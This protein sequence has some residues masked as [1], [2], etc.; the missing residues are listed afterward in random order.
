M[1]FASC[2]QGNGQND[3]PTPTP[4]PVEMPVFAKG[5]DIS[6]VT[7]MEA[8][9]YKFYNANGEEREC[10]ALMK[11]LGFNAVRYRVWVNPADG[12]NS[13]KDVLKKAL[14]AKALGM[15]VMIDFHY[16]DSWADPGKQPIPAAWK[17]FD[18]KQM[19][20]ALVK[21]TK[22]TLSMLHNSGVDVAWVQIGNEVD[23]GMLWE[24][25]RVSNANSSN[26]ITLLNAGYDA[27]KSIYPEAAVILHHSNGQ[28]L[29]EN[30]WF[31]DLMKKGGARYDVLGLSLYPSYWV[32]NGYPD[33]K[34]PEQAF[35][36]NIDA[37]H[38]RYGCPVMLVEVGM[39]A[40]EPDKAET[41]L[42]TLFH[43]TSGRDW[44]Q[45]IFY[46]EPESE[47]QRN[48]YAYGAFAD[49]HPT[50]ALSPFAK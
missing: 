45:G 50:Q 44:F 12:Y 19:T 39:P 20:D 47:Q 8:K 22:E 15:K 23:T 34:A 31:F 37:L 24:V 36:R 28:K 2:D 18:L 6:W 14:R 30:Q 17:G 32:N 3:D 38:I 41:M 35:V 48:N 25:G 43:D 16:S 49:G 42:T 9:G 4:P 11:E 10:T 33:W 5:A 46:W 1:L 26:F 13:S 40:A 29:D 27:V 7:E 21:H